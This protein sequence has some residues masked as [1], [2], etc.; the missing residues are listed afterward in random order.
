LEDIGSSALKDKLYND[1]LESLRTQLAEIDLKH[2]EISEADSFDKFCDPK[3]PVKV[4]F[5]D[6]SAAAYRIKG[7]VEYTPCNVCL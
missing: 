1:R 3:N 5:N 6:I 4:H 2:M 7:G